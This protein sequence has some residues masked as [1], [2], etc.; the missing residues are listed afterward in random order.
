MGSVLREFD[1]RGRGR[2]KRD[3]GRGGR[4]RHGE[5]ESAINRTVQQCDR[6]G[7]V[8]GEAVQEVEV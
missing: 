5:A 2:R 1:G 7:V 8:V 6:Y 4:K 3:F